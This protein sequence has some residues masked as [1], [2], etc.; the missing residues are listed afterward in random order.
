MANKKDNE[1]VDISLYLD[2]E[3]ATKLQKM[4]K[5]KL[6]NQLIVLVLKTRVQQETIDQLEQQVTDHAFLNLQLQQAHRA[7]RALTGAAENQ[8]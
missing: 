3:M 4:T 7:I 2:E 6:L 8:Q 1:C 5:E